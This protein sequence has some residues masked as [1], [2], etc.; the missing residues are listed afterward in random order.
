[1]MVTIGVGFPCCD[2]QAVAEEEKA[3][4]NQHWEWRRAVGEKDPDAG[5]QDEGGDQFLG[6]GSLFEDC[7]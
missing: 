4:G 5:D 6:N 7:S 3:E 1:M 2:E